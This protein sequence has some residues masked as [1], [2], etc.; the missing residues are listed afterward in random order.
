MHNVRCGSVRI[1]IT[2]TQ[3]QEANLEKASLA[4]KEIL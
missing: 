2:L 1:S 4:S 3:E